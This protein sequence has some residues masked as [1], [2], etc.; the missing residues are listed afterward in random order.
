MREMIVKVHYQKEFKKP[1]VCYICGNI[2]LDEFIELEEA[3]Q[4]I[5]EIEKEGDYEFIFSFKYEEGA[6]DNGWSY[7]LVGFYPIDE[8][9]SISKTQLM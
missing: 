9:G 5:P 4:T 7:E 2:V 1:F 6:I 3:I 8:D